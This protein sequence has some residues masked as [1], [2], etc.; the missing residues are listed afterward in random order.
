[1]GELIGEGARVSD[2]VERLPD[3]VREARKQGKDVARE[4]PCLDRQGLDFSP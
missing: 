3:L 4:S 2:T 1:M